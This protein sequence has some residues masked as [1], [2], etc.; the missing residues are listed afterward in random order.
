MPKGVR[1]LPLGGRGDIF[2]S[3][4]LAAFSVK[5]PEVK[6]GKVVSVGKRSVSSL[7]NV[8]H[9]VLPWLLDVGIMYG[10]PLNDPLLYHKTVGALQHFILTHPEI[11]Y[12]IVDFS[13]SS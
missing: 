9:C 3:T 8:D 12:V 10:V 13:V 6:G 2:L 11:A 5:S 7:V 4:F 1:V